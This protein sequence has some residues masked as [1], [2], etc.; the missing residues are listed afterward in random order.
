MGIFNISAGAGVNSTTI[1]SV[2]TAKLVALRTALEA[3]NDLQGW[4]SGVAVTD[5]EGIGFSDTDASALLSA[6]A[7]AGALYSI[8]ATGQPPDT[9]PQAASAYV[10]AASQRQVMG[11]S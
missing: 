7:D 8:Y 1:G 10:Y 11:V 4:A 6:I 3:V 5:L 9:Y 2:V